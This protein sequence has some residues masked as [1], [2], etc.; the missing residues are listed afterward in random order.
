[1]YGRNAQKVNFAQNYTCLYHL[2][3]SKVVSST[4]ASGSTF[5]VT[6]FTSPLGNYK[7]LYLIN[8]L[9]VWI[10]TDNNLDQSNPDQKKV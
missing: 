6:F 1:M 4:G 5:D 7:Y 9:K 3:P 10:S 2:L 8:L